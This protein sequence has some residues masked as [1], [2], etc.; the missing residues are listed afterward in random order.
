[1][2]QSG[3]VSSYCLYTLNFYD[4]AI[5]N[6]KRFKNYTLPIKTWIMGYLIAVIYYE[7]ILD[8]KRYRK[9]NFYKKSN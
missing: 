8:E 3:F 2:Q 7:Q 9:T 1:M 4:E 5:L 6:L